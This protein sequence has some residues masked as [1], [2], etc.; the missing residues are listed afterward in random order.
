VGPRAKP[1]VRVSGGEAPEADEFVIL[2]TFFA[3]RLK[4]AA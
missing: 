4:V 2:G 3:L 1:L